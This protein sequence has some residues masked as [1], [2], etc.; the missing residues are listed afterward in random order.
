MQR[1]CSELRE[2]SERI[3]RA[4]VAAVMPECL[5]Q[6]HVHLDG[7][8]LTVDEELID[9]RSV[10]RIAIVGGGKAAGAMAIALENIF[11]PRLLAEKSVSGWV[12]VPSDCVPTAFELSSTGKRQSESDHISRIRI[13]AGRPAGINEPRPEGVIGTQRIL[14]IVS[15]LGPNDLCFCMLAGGG[16]ALLPA[17]VPEI[18][19][20][21]KI[22]VTRLLSG[23]GANI[24]QLNAVRRA[25]SLVKG[26]GLARACGS[27]RLITLIISD[28]LGDPFEAIASGPTVKTSTSAADAFAILQQLKLADDPSIATVVRYLRNEQ[29]RP[30]RTAEPIDEERI[31]N[32]I[33]GNNATAVDAAGIEAERLG[34]SHAMLSARAPEGSAEEVGRHLAEMAVRMRDKAGPDC[35]ISGGEPTVTLV[36][37]SHRGKGGRNQQ[38]ALAA[39]TELSDCLGIALLSAGT[40]GEDGPTDAAGAIVTSEITRIARAKNLNPH[41][42][43]SR[44]DAYHFFE[45]SGGLFRTGPTQTNV[46]DLRVITVNRAT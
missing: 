26:G 31:T 41:D 18:S 14:E 25:L 15:L 39:L 46:C 9:L 22:R 19:L 11:G 30:S 2:D 42:Y 7:D 45:S 20:D 29:R 10:G 38:L 12:N 27:G 35:L 16:S 8:W 37:E 13:H 40:D 1:T 24:E 43:L 28:V 5:I 6:S 34:Y 44:N 17:P 36:E 4:G 32:L 23:A 3:W 33:I 21:D